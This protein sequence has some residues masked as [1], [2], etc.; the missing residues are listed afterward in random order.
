MTEQEYQTVILAALLHDVGKFMQRAEVE[1]KHEKNE[2]EMQLWCPKWNGIPTHR[3]VLWTRSFFDDYS[4]YFPDLSNPSDDNLG[5]LATRHHSPETLLQWIITEADRLS[6]GMDRLPKDEEDEATGKDAFKRIRLRS[7]LGEVCL[8]DRKIETAKY[9]YELNPLSLE[10]IFPEPKEELIP[11]EGELLVPLYKNLWEGFVDEF[12]RLPRQTPQSFTT[13]LIYLLEK[14][15][16]CIPSSTIDLP[17]ISLFDHSKTTA[18][19]AACLYN[20][21]SKNKTLIEQ[22]IKDRNGKKYLL[23]CGDLSGIQKFIYKISSK[24]AAKGLKGRSFYLQLLLETMAKHILRKT[25]YPLTNLLYSGGGKCYLL[26][27]SACEGILKDTSKEINQ[28]LMEKFKGEIYFALGWSCFNGSDFIISQEDNFPQIWKDAAEASNQRKRQKF[29][30]LDYKDVFNVVG[31]GA[32][33]AI[34]DICKNEG[35]LKPFRDESEIMICSDCRVYDDI[36]TNLARANYI[37]EIYNE[38]VGH[39]EKGVD[40]KFADTKY[41]FL[42]DMI[43]LSRVVSSEMILYAINDTEGFLNPKESNEDIAYGFKFIGGNFA[44][45]DENGNILTFDGLAEESSGGLKRLGVLRMDVDNLG[46]IFIKGLKE[47]AS[48][49]RI[50]ELSRRLAI[51]FG[52]FLNKIAERYKGKVY[53][54]YSGGDDL[55]IVGAWDVMPEIARDISREFKRFACQNPDF[56]LSGGISLIPKKYPI[57]KGAELAG[58]A[59]EDAKGYKRDQKEKDAMCFL[60]TVVGW[61]EFEIVCA[62]KNMLIGCIGRGLNKGIIDRLRWIY[63]LY[64][65]NKN[66]TLRESKKRGMS[67]DAIKERIKHNQWLWRMVYSLT[68]YSKDNKL[69]EEEVK[70]L[71][72]AIQGKEFN[73]VKSEREIID[74]LNLPTRWAEFLLREEV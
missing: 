74:F 48:I 3:H 65:K 40:F 47:K 66:E 23:V 39:K 15:T 51:F 26:V 9:R 10:T 34:C 68:K 73:G 63:L 7:V 5:N 71:I 57:Y 16:W 35:E 27:D 54:I 38:Q 17:D 4:N 21:H 59:E 1:C 20:Y 11:P 55:F 61:N 19:I 28:F 43:D 67:I 72:C 50:T 60:D 69:F 2:K 33:K 30:E 18:A 64:L 32:D 56:S 14:Y 22:S 37:L 12:K 41:Y 25:E 46:L 24:G 53:I 29:S 31:E 52:G 13:S 62:I 8:G 44:P 58:E 49:S 42:K 36:G 6:S 45:Q 70:E